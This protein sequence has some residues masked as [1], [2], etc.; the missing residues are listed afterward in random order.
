[1]TY[2]QNENN[3]FVHNFIDHI[4]NNINLNNLNI[5]IDQIISRVSIG[6][7]IVDGYIFNG[8]DKDPIIV[9]GTLTNEAFE[10]TTN[11]ENIPVCEPVVIGRPIF[12][13]DALN[14][15]VMICTRI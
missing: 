11:E 5:N 3:N 9:N 6:I 13:K 8:W 15:C 1:M 2:L 7:P 14:V 12:P 10:Y 4:M